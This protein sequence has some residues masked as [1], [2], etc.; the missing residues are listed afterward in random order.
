MVELLMK[1]IVW[2]FDL[3]AFII[4]MSLFFEVAIP[5]KFKTLHKVY[6]A[7]F[8]FEEDEEL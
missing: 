6:Q 4:V 3:S 7:I 5:G 1:A 2:L 8:E